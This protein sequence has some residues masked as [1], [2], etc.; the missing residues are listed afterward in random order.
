[1][2]PFD[3]RKPFVHR[4]PVKKIYV[5]TLAGFIGFSTGFLIV[6]GI[7]PL[8]KYFNLLK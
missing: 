5:Y 8:K 6:F 3:L 7:L 4:K 2:E 1:M